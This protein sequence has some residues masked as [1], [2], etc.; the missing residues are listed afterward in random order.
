MAKRLAPELQL[1][2]LS[3]DD[4]KEVLYDTLGAPDRASSRRLGAAAYAVLY[5]IAARVLSY[6]DGA[7][8]E[9]A[10]MRGLAEPDL[11]RLCAG[12]AAFLIHCEAPR[13]VVESRLR[14]GR[15]G[16][17]P[18]HHDAAALAEILAALDE[19]RYGPLD[20]GISTMR[21]S[22]ADGYEPPLEAVSAFI[23]AQPG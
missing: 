5:R 16:R 10:F 7:V 13:H 4:I 6:G 8:V 18:Q 14:S 12:R 17:H 21:L 3:S 22:T 11:L 9:G 19:G 20:L 23:A 15:P 2:L 1:P